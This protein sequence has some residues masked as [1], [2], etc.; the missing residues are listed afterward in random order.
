ML[1]NYFL[2]FKIYLNNLDTKK[3]ALSNHYAGGCSESL[4]I[5]YLTTRNF[6]LI[7]VSMKRTLALAPVGFLMKSM[8]FW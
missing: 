2:L 6:N 1:Q 4:F 7:S 8:I 3:T 5:G